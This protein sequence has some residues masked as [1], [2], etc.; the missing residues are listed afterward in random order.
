MTL[1]PSAMAHRSA[2]CA[3]YCVSPGDPRTFVVTAAVLGL[4]GL[5]ASYLP[6]RAATSVQPVTALRRD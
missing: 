3:L 6:A 1:T 2:V 5:L 4:V